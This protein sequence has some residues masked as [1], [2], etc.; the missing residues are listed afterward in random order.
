MSESVIIYGAGGMAHEVYEWS[1]CNGD[2]SSIGR[3]VAYTTDSG[4]DRD[5]ESS[6]RLPFIE[7]GKALETYP[8]LHAL[9]CIGDPTGRKVVTER[10]LSQGIKLKTFIHP[11]VLLAKSARVG[12][13]S[14]IYPFAVISSN[15][16]LGQSCIVNSYSGVGHDVEIGDYCTISAQVDLTGFVKL[17]EG[18]FVGSG[19]RVVP[20]KKIGAYSKISAGTTVIRSLSDHSIVL[21]KATGVSK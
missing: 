12:A 5:F 13:G 7:L 2:S 1:F 18:V 11:T 21:P 3:V 8:D 16:R 20:K 17:G 4:L 15:A 19:A 14:V 10:L 9:V 6:T